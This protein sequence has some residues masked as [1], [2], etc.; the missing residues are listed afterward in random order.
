MCRPFPRKASNFPISHRV[1]VD[2]RSFACT[3]LHLG[4]GEGPL[5][6]FVPLPPAASTL[7]SRRGTVGMS[8][9]A[10]LMEVSDSYCSPGSGVC[11][12]PQAGL[13]V[14]EM[15]AVRRSALGT[16]ELSRGVSLATSTEVK[17]SEP[18]EDRAHRFVATRRLSTPGCPLAPRSHV[19]HVRHQVN[20]SSFI[21]GP[22]VTYPRSIP[23]HPET[24]SR[25][26]WR[27]FCAAQSW[28]SHLG[29]R[30]QGRVSPMGVAPRPPPTSAQT[31][32]R[33]KMYRLQ[34]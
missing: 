27:S 12:S 2:A 24:E 18:V 5:P 4:R 20:K 7:P 6:G 14:V 8:G 28:H 33:W 29:S 30:S 10:G 32:P 23:K 31:A 9:A 15:G 25:L 19:S 22:S 13:P 17:P 34:A 26:A 3:C 1:C 16:H 21:R 11:M